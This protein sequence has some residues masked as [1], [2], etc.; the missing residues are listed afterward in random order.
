MRGRP[1]G[2]YKGVYAQAGG[3]Y[4]WRKEQSH[5]RALERLQATQRATINPRQQQVINQVEAQD[6]YNQSNPENRVIP[7]SSGRIPLR[8]IM[9]EIDFSANLFP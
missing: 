9:D 2:T 7:D 4:N 3:V 1:R 8:K 6:R 5:R